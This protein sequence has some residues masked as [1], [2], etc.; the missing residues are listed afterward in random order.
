M[1]KQG[2]RDNINSI[3]RKLTSL[4]DID[5]DVINEII[6][7]VKALLNF[8]L[9]V[10]RKIANKKKNITKDN[11]RPNI[12]KDENNI[13]SKQKQNNNDAEFIISTGKFEVYFGMD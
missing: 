10:Q 4:D 13:E 7:D 8:K 12:I 11:Q 5:E 1:S 9:D 3:K 6:E 2:M